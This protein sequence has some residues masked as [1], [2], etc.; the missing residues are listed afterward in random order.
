[1]GKVLLEVDLIRV[2]V[3][4]IQ[5]VEVDGGYWY[6]HSFAVNQGRT[7]YIYVY[8]TYIQFTFP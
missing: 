1:M 7:K 8:I 2:D 6:V 4:E 3:A 5:L